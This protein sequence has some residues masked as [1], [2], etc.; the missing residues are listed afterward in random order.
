[1]C[2]HCSFQAT[3]VHVNMG[4]CATDQNVAWMV[5]PS[6]RHAMPDG[7]STTIRPR[8]FVRADTT[9]HKYEVVLCGNLHCRYVANTCTCD[10]GVPQTAA[11][12][13]WN[14]AP[15][16]VSCN[17]GWTL[18]REKAQ[19]IRTRLHVHI[20]NKIIFAHACHAFVGNVCTCDN[21]VPPTG[22]YCPVNGAVKCESCNAG[23]TIN[24]AR[25]QCTRTCFV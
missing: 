19:C 3:S 4:W 20:Q 24:D 2:L 12:C 15:K 5:L 25:S 23:W 1:M 18:Q 8:V 22:V 6:V 10:H 21:G 13:P 11:G 17:T 7:R 14:G 9:K 16:C